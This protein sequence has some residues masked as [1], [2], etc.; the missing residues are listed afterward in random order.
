MKWITRARPKTDRIAC[1]W[2]IRRFIDPEAEIVFI[3]SDRVLATA[4]ELDGRSLTPQAPSS[5]TG[6]AS[7]PSRSS[8]TSSDSVRTRPWRG[9]PGSFTPPTSQKT[10]IP[11]HSGPGCSPSES[12]A[13]KSRLMTTACSTK[14]CSPMTPSTLGAASRQEGDRSRSL[15][16]ALRRR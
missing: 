6:N 14:G 9:W 15:S 7:A 13:S 2:L 12:E 8:S 11:T 5:L 16:E 10:S 3:A 1:P 4:A